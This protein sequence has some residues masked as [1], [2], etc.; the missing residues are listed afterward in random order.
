MESE[1]IN[2]YAKIG[3]NQHCS[4]TDDPG[5]AWVAIDLDPPSPSHIITNTSLWVIKSP[6]NTDVNA[7]RD[8]RLLRVYFNGVE[9]QTRT[10]D[11][12][13]L[14]GAFS[15][16]LAVLQGIGTW[17]EDFVWIASDDTKISMSMV[18]V[19]EFGQAVAKNEEVHVMA[20]NALKTMPNIPQDYTDDKWWPNESYTSTAY[21]NAAKSE[22]VEAS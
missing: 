3:T 19:I 16:A 22:E 12:L 17:D 2:K 6:E 15:K 10:K 21:R 11:I 14:N 4:G 1:M 20:G 13:R 7:E 5:E 9:F 18:D 8:T